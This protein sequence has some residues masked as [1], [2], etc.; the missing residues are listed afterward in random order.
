[1]GESFLGFPNRFRVIDN[2]NESEFNPNHALSARMG[3]EL[4]EKFKRYLPLTGGI[5]TGDIY[6]LNILP[7]PDEDG[8]DIGSDHS[9]FSN[10]YANTLYGSL[11]GN[12]S[13]ASKWKNA[14]MLKVSGSVSGQISFDGSDNIDLECETTH[15]HDEL[16]LKLT[17]GSLSGNIVLGKNAM[18][19]NYINQP[20]LELSSDYVLRLH[21]GCYN[22]KKGNV[23]IYSHGDFDIRTNSS[24]LTLTSSQ[25][26]KTV[27]VGVSENSVYMENTESH[28]FLHIKD[29][30]DLMLNEYLVYHSGIF[31]PDN[32]IKSSYKDHINDLKKI[33]KV[34]AISLDKLEVSS[35]VKDVRDYPEYEIDDNLE[36]YKDHTMEILNE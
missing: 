27:N 3:Y 31:N 5:M 7:V 34:L 36:H 11:N 19:L 14:R 32:Y 10:I 6:T 15:N 20:L 13:S 33:I 25:F 22:S 9:R 17:G 30:G 26:N 16:Y 8:Y 18:V 29:N 23:T 1:M 2:P 4:N 28:S 12:A 24:G 21:Q 35:G